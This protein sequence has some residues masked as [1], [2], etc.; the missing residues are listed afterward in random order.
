MFCDWV[1]ELNI[2]TSACTIRPT[3]R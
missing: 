1:F 3:G 2:H